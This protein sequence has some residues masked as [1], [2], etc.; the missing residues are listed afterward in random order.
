MRTSH[1]KQW[2]AGLL[3][4]SLLVAT[5]MGCTSYIPSLFSRK[6][7]PAKAPAKSKGS[8]TLY[9]KHK[10]DRGKLPRAEERGKDWN[11]RSILPAGLRSERPTDKKKSRFGRFALPGFRKDKSPSTRDPFLDASIRDRQQRQHNSGSARITERSH[12]PGTTRLDSRSNSSRNQFVNGFDKDMRELRAERA[13]LQRR[14]QQQPRKRPAN[15]FDLISRTKDK[16]AE[17]SQPKTDTRVP[18]ISD[19]SVNTPPP[20]PGS[21]PVQPASRAVTARKTTPTPAPKNQ[22]RN[23]LEDSPF[24]QS[25]QVTA[26]K[27]PAAIKPPIPDV[28]P[29]TKSVAIPKAAA[30]PFAEL[31]PSTSQPVKTVPWTTP[32]EPAPRSNRKNPTVA[33]LPQPTFQADKSMI[34]DSSATSPTT[35]HPRAAILLGHPAALQPSE[36]AVKHS[37]P[38]KRRRIE[39]PAPEIQ[40]I[41][42]RKTYRMTPTPNTSV[43]KGRK[44]T[45]IRQVSGERRSIDSTSAI[46]DDGQLEWKPVSLKREVP[47]PHKDDDAWQPK[48]R[49]AAAP[50]EQ[51]APLPVASARALSSGGEGKVAVAVGDFSGT[52]EQPQAAGTGVSPLLLAIGLAIVLLAGVMYHRHRQTGI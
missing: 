18:V 16:V 10:A 47:K 42:R 32:V 20:F 22:G 52:D 12:R 49:V 48:S 15:P 29:D 2:H 44:E 24:G 37:Q 39:K 36:P 35:K 19:K 45:Q 31:P 11:R 3:A 14:Q 21:T 34:V 26:N 41:P 33:T 9:A 13:R 23:A 25:P 6:D 4:G 1:K 17:T 43:L 51:P 46:P 28:T 30:N 50:D 8:D 5:V 38:A 7:D 40:I 27:A